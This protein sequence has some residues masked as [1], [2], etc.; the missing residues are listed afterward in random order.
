MATLDH[1]ANPN[2][3]ESSKGNPAKRNS[4]SKRSYPCSIVDFPDPPSKRIALDAADEDRSDTEALEETMFADRDSESVTV[5][6]GKNLACLKVIGGAKPAN[7]TPS[8]DILDFY[9][10]VADIDLN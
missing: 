8:S 3:K 4:I 10:A 5:V 6:W 9:K 7:W 2:A 1:S